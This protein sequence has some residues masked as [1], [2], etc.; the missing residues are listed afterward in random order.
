MFDLNKLG[1]MTKIAGQAR[2]LQEKQEKATQKH[3]ELL[4]K[5]SCQLDTVID[6]LKNK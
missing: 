2:Q 6:I 3:T 4:E 5:I 1:D